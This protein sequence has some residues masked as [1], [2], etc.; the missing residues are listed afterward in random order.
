[1][2]ILDFFY[3]GPI[4]APFAN[5]I[6]LP[7]LKLPSVSIYQTPVYRTLKLPLVGLLR[8]CICKCSGLILLARKSEALSELE[9]FISDG[10]CDVYAQLHGLR[11]VHLFFLT[12]LL[13]KLPPLLAVVAK[14][15]VTIDRLANGNAYTIPDPWQ[16]SRKASI[17]WHNVLRSI[18]EHRYKFWRWV[19]FKNEAGHSPFEVS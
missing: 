3:L 7:V 15:L 6:L 19:A 13:G 11:A 4:F 17:F 9:H 5:D 18:D 16:E 8:P 2:K 12:R 14:Q 10:L 1:M